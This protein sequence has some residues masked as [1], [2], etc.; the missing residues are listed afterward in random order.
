MPAEYSPC[1]I[2]ILVTIA[3]GCLKLELYCICDIYRY[4]SYEILQI[5]QYQDGIYC[6]AVL[7]SSVIRLLG[8]GI[9]RF[10]QL[11]GHTQPISP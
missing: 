2:P 4:L 5:Y 8:R 6:V 7:A 3:M 9:K 1:L 11:H 10:H